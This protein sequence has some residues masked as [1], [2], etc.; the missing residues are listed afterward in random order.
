MST[1]SARTA[2]TASS[3]CT[4]WTRNLGH[5]DVCRDERRGHTLRDNWHDMCTTAATCPSSWATWKDQGTVRSR[6]PT[7]KLYVSSSPVDDGGKLSITPPHHQ[8]DQRLFAHGAATGNG[9]QEP[10]SRAH[11]VARSSGGG[12]CTLRL[13]NRPARTSGTLMPSSCA[14]TTRLRAKRMEFE[15]P[16]PADFKN[17]MLRK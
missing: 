3:W 1:W 14:S 8:A 13:R 11:A 16:Y 7:A 6:L 15:T 9:T 4:V 17:L 5:H 10:D 12:R 2:T